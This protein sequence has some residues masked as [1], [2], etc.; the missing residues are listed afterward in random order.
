[1]NVWMVNEKWGRLFATRE[2]ALAYARELAEQ[3]MRRQERSFPTLGPYRIEERGH[4]LT[5]CSRDYDSYH[6][7]VT[8]REVEE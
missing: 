8:Q 7:A 3:Y 4:G 5:V 1:M 6:F 2:L